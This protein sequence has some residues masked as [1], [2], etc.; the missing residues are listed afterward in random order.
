ML[1][2]Y[3]K[4][5]FK[6]KNKTIKDIRRDNY[7]TDKVLRDIKNLFN[8]DKEGYYKPIRTSNDFSSNYIEYESNGD[9]DKTLSIKEYL[10][11][12]KVLMKLVLFI[13]RLIT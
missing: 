2:K 4:N 8:S 13:Q 10:D 6:S 11:K 9:K 3:S 5:I 12:I 1:I 7:D